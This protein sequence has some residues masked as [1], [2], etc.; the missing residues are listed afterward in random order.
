[1]R[2]FIGGGK[3]KHNDRFST[4][5]PDVV[6]SF[7][8]EDDNPRQ[9]VRRAQYCDHA[10]VLQHRTSHKHIDCLKKNNV[11]VRFT[12][13]IPVVHILIQQILATNHTTHHYTGAPAWAKPPTS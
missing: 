6:F 10:I 11:A 8:S 1:M 5:Y 2:I 12:D 9:W 3:T 13:S 4:R 7:A